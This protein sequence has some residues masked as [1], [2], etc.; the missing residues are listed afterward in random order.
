MSK[1]K[2]H[3]F[4]QNLVGKTTKKTSFIK[5]SLQSTIFVNA[6]FIQINWMQIVNAPST[7]LN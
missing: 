7:P 5:Y 1:L 2:V 6:N 4:L 3:M